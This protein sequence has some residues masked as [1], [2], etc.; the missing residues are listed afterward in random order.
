MYI[1]CVLHAIVAETSSRTALTDLYFE[2]HTTVLIAF[3]TFFNASC[4]ALDLTGI[5]PP[6]S[7]SSPDST[8]SSTVEL[9]RK[10]SDCLDGK[11]DLL[12]YVEDG[13]LGE[14]G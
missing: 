3:W 12:T 10:F 2:T 8:N 14:Q 11:I 13:P 1:L 4:V 9:D 5:L 7:E 6:N